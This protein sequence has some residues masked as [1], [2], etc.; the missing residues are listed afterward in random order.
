MCTQN[1][2]IPSLNYKQ[3]KRV[4]FM[5]WEGIYKSSVFFDYTKKPD[6]VFP[7]NFPFFWALLS[8]F[9]VTHKHGIYC[10][11]SLYINI[12]RICPR[13][14]SLHFIFLNLF[15]QD[16]LK[17]FFTKKINIIFVLIQTVLTQ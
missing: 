12:N 16:F 15:F 10:Y 7:K 14:G 9:E 11:N 5:F 3:Y 4:D 1:H 8:D 13:Q 2:V 17:A 6:K